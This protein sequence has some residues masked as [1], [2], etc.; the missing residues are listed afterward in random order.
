[1]PLKKIN[2]QGVLEIEAWLELHHIDGYTICE[3]FWL[4][5]EWVVFAENLINQKLQPEL[6]IA[7]WNSKSG[8]GSTFLILDDFISITNPKQGYTHAHTQP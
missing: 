6:S 8:E 2:N 1:M 5:R 3:R 4:L 7:E